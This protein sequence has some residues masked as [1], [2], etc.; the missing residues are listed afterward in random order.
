MSWYEGMGYCN[1]LN[2]EAYLAE[3]NNNGTHNFITEW[4][5]TH[6]EK[7]WWWLGGSN[8]E[9]NFSKLSIRTN[10]YSVRNLKKQSVYL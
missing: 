2:R 10:L 9:V 4:A 7:Q 6:L 5:D 1:N 3:D 8:F